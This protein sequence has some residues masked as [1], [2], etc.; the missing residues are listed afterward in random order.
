MLGSA[1][2]AHIFYN[3]VSSCNTRIDDASKIQIVNYVL[4][5]DTIYLGNCLCL[6]A[7]I[8]MQRQENIFFVESC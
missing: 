7:C 1:C 2:G 6:R 4:E 3:I 5:A 8:Y